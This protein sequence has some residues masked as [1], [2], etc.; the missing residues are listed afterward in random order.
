MS[1]THAQVSKWCAL[2]MVKSIPCIM[3]HADWPPYYHKTVRLFPQIFWTSLHSMNSLILND[4]AVSETAVRC[5][6]IHT[7]YTGSRAFKI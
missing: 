7:M 1:V 3:S 4:P 5:S 2:R 6:V